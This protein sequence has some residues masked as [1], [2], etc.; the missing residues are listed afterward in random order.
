MRRTTRQRGMVK[1]LLLI[2]TILVMISQVAA[3]TY[4]KGIVSLRGERRQ[5]QLRHGLRSPD[6]SYFP[7]L[8]RGNVTLI[9]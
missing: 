6:P 3:Q 5:H 8:R 4:I 2:A 7:M 9:N 1:W